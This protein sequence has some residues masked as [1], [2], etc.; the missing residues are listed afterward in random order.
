MASDAEDLGARRDWLMQP[1]SRDACADRAQGAKW[2]DSVDTPSRGV[3]AIDQLLRVARERTFERAR[4]CA[5]SRELD[6]VLLSFI[7]ATQEPDA[8]LLARV[9][10]SDWY[11]QLQSL[12][13]LP[14]L[15]QRMLNATAVL[16]PEANRARFALPI[17]SQD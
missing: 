13:D 6:P 9:S 5:G 14:E 16:A 10:T 4:A 1:S 8:T 17:G 15:S 7:T 3:P 2:V 11:A 12:Q